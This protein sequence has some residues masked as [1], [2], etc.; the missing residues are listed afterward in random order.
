M[1]PIKQISFISLFASF[2]SAAEANSPPYFVGVLELGPKGCET[3]ELCT[4]Q[5]DFAY[6]D[7]HGVGWKVNSGFKTDGASIPRWAQWFAGEP[8][9]PD[10]LQAAVLHDWYSK[11]VRPV[12]G[13]LQ[14]QRMFREVLLQ[15]GVSLGKANLLYG[16]VLAGSGKWIWRK[17]GRVCD[18][19]AGVVCLQEVGRFELQREAA[20]FGSIEHDQVLEQLKAE[21]NFLDAA[22]VQDVEKLVDG[23]LGG[24]VYIQ[25]KDGVIDVQ[26]G[27][28]EYLRFSK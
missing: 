15:S 6:V 26:N 28:E 20:S 25:E 13:W 1:K 16:G 2:M 21:K 23:L 4:V 10:Y 5:N 24:S 12:Y 8:F 7:R 22:S 11:S 14:T 27:I 18:L 17:E 3:V 9:E 19:G